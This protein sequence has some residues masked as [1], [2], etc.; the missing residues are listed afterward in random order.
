MRKFVLVLL[1]TFMGFM[2]SENSDATQEIM[3]GVLRTKDNVSIA[4]DRYKNGF[5]SVIIVCPGFYNS[6][7]N[8]WMKKTV[9]LLSSRYDV[10]IFD[11]RGHG[12]SGGKFTWSA[13]EDKDINAVLDYAKSEGY[14]D[15]GIVA[16]SLGAASSINAASKRDDI[17]SMV[18]I[19]CPSSFRMIDYHFWKPEMFVDLWDN[20]ECNWQGKGARASHIFIPK[21]KPIK[22]IGKIKHTPMFF[23]HG[24]KDWVIKD[25]HSRKLYDAAKTDKKIEIIKNGLHA[26]R[27]VQFHADRMQKLMLD[28]FAKSFKEKKG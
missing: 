18:L 14:K 16:F 26:E 4:Y 28:W 3:S 19:S 20:V 6:K 1:I 25:R 27:L 9:E 17:D 8:R 5:D 7:E 21:E 23:I 12:K 22:T 10:I 24:D 15:I 13:R 11:L 2:S